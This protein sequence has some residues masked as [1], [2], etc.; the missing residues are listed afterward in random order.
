MKKGRFSVYTILRYI[1][2]ILLI[3]SVHFQ[4]KVEASSYYPLQTKYP[5]TMIY[6]VDT[7]EKVIAFTFDDGPDERYTPEILDVLKKHDVKATFFLLGTRVD[8][9][10]EVVKRIH[11]EGHAIGNHTYW[12][13]ELTKKPDGVASLVWETNKNEQA[14]ESVIGL[15]TNLFR[16]PY[17][18]INGEMI[19][20]LKEMNYQAVGWSIDS[21]DWKGLS[22]NK[23]K[24]NV[25]SGLHPGSIVLMHSAGRVP[26]TPEALDELLRYLK[27]NGYMIVTIPDLWKV[28]YK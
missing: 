19:E 2:I 27:T 5:D 6:K 23:I 24:H 4:E 25:I 10:P 12:H 3:V 7:N 16:A 1:T 18:A 22:K 17:G 21:E 14:I 9:Y 13:P 15:K 8:K 28:Q 20:K 11:E 26:G